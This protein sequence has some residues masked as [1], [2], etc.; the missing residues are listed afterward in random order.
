MAD[1]SKVIEPR[2]ELFK[3][4]W[5]QGLLWIPT[6][7]RDLI[8]WFMAFFVYFLWGKHI[9]RVPWSGM[10]TDLKPDSWPAR[11]WYRLKLLNKETGKMEYVEMPEQYRERYGRWLTW[12]GTTFGHGGFYGPG[13]MGGLPT[14]SNKEG[15]WALE[16]IDEPVEYHEN[17]HVGQY[18]G[19]MMRSCLYGVCL[20]V[21]M[22]LLSVPWQTAFW[23]GLGVW[24]SGFEVY[25]IT[26]GIVSVL[27]GKRFYA[28]SDH[29]K[30][31]Y[32]MTEDWVNKER[33]GQW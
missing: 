4:K 22:A 10:W 18:E 20:F 23:I 24:V 15:L 14:T 6:F 29:E 31:A 8:A 1:T 21:S 28:D 27:R 12:G 32:A 9:R 30:Q 26:N 3:G 25:W 33:G 5:Y 16:L 2:Y 11:T 13:K 19:A 7:P 17:I